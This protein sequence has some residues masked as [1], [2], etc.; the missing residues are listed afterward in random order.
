MTVAEQVAGGQ[1]AA[2][3]VVDAEVGGL[4]AGDG[5]VDDDGADPG[6]LQLV[7]AAGRPGVPVRGADQQQAL[8]AQLQELPD[9]SGLALVVLGGVAE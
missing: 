2:A 5:A 6:A 1:V 7:Q 9:I 3:K 8:D 4:Q